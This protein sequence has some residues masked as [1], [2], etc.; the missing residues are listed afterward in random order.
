MI[1]SL[2]GYELADALCPGCLMAVVPVARCFQERC[3]A[4]WSKDGKERRER[5]LNE[6]NRHTIKRDLVENR[7]PCARAREGEAPT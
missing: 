6:T 5:D 4:A 7:N 2:P 1:P 3:A